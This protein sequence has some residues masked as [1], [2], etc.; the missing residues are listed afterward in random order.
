M[1]IDQ[2]TI[3]VLKSFSTINPSLLFKEGTTITTI[4]PGGSILAKAIV[5][6]EFA[7]RF[8]IY[9]LDRFLSSASLFDDPE[10]TF[11][12]KYVTI[13]D[14]SNRKIDYVF[15]SE[16]TIVVPPDKELS[17]DG[18]EASFTLTQT[19]MKQLERGIGVL[20]LT[21]VAIVGD[22]D[23]LT[24]KGIDSTGTYADSYTLVLGPTDKTFK[25]IIEV[26][27]LKIMAGD[28][29]VEVGKRK[30]KTIIRFYNNELE[31]WVS[32]KAVN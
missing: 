24:F 30:S 10:F 20:G 8:A 4:A 26:E 28:Y 31:Y 7:N 13:S 18:V 21:E 15:C 3:S 32:T 12:D 2:K 19:Q 27:N 23:T 29:T 17:F 9:K 6:T 1:K 16:N 14:G 11:H 25:A 5:P 22:G